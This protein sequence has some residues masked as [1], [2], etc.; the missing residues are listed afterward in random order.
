MSCAHDEHLFYFN[1]IF[2]QNDF[3]CAA[4]KYRGCVISAVSILWFCKSKHQ[5]QRNYVRN[6][7][8]SRITTYSACTII[9]NKTYWIKMLRKKITSA[10]TF[11]YK[12]RY[13]EQYGWNSYFPN[14]KIWLESRVVMLFH[15][16]NEWKKFATRLG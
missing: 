9:H 4:S 3:S 2:F 7:I 11:L 8:T 12:T 1:K 6:S 15:E 10:S 14:G 13:N 5:K 16:W